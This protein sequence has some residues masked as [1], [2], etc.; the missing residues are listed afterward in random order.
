MTHDTTD[1]SRSSTT[2]VTTWYLSMSSPARL[3]PRRVQ[4][5]DVSIARIDPPWP[6]LSRFLYTEVGA[7][8]H[9]VDRLQWTDT[10]WLQR[11]ERSGVETWLLSVAGLP[12]GYFELER[13]GDDVEIV[14]F[15]LF[16]RFTGQGLGAHLLT[17]AVERAW[18][19]DARRVWLHTCSFDHPAALANYRARGFDL[20]REETAERRVLPGP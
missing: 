20:D 16:S 17:V 2:R 10:N 12:A 15:G 9:W 8:W 13:Q 5:R 11:L 3:S 7:D 19:M 4:R 18:A 14:Y 6:G 1:G